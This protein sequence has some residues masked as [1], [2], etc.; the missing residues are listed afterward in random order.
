MG[1]ARFG[2]LNLGIAKFLFVLLSTWVVQA[3]HVGCLKPV[4]FW[5]VFMVLFSL[6][7]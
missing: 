6:L 3:R 4:R 7:I 5:L 1:I 2:A